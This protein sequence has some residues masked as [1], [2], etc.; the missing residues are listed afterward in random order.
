MT[1]EIRPSK[2]SLGIVKMLEMIFIFVQ[3]KYILG[4][5]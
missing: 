5:L 3:W 1:D 2:D 4:R